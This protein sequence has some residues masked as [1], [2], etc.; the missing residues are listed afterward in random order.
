V[1]DLSIALVLAVSLTVVRLGAGLSAD[2]TSPVHETAKPFTN[3]VASWDAST[4]GGSWIEVLLR[5]RI[6]ERF[7]RWYE[8]G[9]WS[10]SVADGHRHSIAKQR[11]ADGSVATDTL[12]LS[13]P[14]SAWQLQVIMHPGPAGER[15]VLQLVAVTTDEAEAQHGDQTSSGAPA[16]RAGATTPVAWG[17]ELDVPERTQRIDESP[18]ALGGGGDAWCS[19]TSVSMVMAYWAERLH[20]PQWSVAVPVAASG[21]YDP[22][23]DGCGNW[24]FNVA[25]AS[26]HGLGGWVERLRGL[27]DMEPYLLSGVPLV[28]S[29]RVKPGELAGS[30]YKET[31]GHLL[32]VRGFTD[33][34]DVITNDPAALPGHIRI[35]YQRAEFEHV[36]MGGSGGIV[37]VIAPPQTLDAFGRR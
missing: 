3:A 23:Y 28:A 7:T 26:E 32:V 6:G 22:V 9:H 11:D 5:A 25:F 10:H 1:G 15:P 27:S 21:T 35:V 31:D 37:Y 2:Y 14:A 34:G 16:N 12:L 20:H 19:P 24:P 8:M 36:W 33:A 18:D 29:I 30:P 4:Q 17:R 13:V